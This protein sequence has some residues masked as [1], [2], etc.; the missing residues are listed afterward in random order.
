MIA[1]TNILE[2]EA[3]DIRIILGD[4]RNG[5]STIATGFAIDDY[6]AHMENI[7]SPDGDWIKAKCLTRDELDWLWKK[8][9]KAYP[10]THCRIF[11][12]GESKIIEIPPKFM[13][14]S[15]VKIFANYTLYGV[16]YVPLDMYTLIDNINGDLIK[17]AYV[18]MDESAMTDARDSMTT[19]GK[20]TAKFGAQVGKRHLHFCN[21]SQNW[22]IVES[23]YRAFKTTS[24]WCTYDKEA[25]IIECDIQQKGED[26]YSEELYAPPY[27]RFFDSSE[28]VKVPQH[29]VDAALARIN[30][31]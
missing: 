10:V 29:R 2:T 18:L 20:M 14:D 13:V 7:I 11:R 4:Q 27:W 25:H 21:I 12:G 26:S 31:R 8:G 23:R 30:G 16:Y 5:K 24:I 17:D 15:Q 9:I 28:I 1:E 22:A 6:I 3:A 19:E